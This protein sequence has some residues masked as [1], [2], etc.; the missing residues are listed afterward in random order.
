MLILSIFFGLEQRSLFTKKEEKKI[1]IHNLNANTC[2]QILQSSHQNI[3]SDSTRIY[4][5]RSINSV[6]NLHSANIL[7]LSHPNAAFATSCK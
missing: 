5:T 4:S 7:Y 1:T 6:L 2:K 3:C